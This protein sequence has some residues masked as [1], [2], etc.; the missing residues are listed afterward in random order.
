MQVPNINP[1]IRYAAIHYNHF[2]KPYD[3]LCYDCR[4]FFIKDAKGTFTVNSERLP[5]SDCTVFYLP[6]GSKYHM[7]LRKE[8]RTPQ[9]AVIDF[10]LVQDFNYLHASLSTA[11]EQTFDAKRVIVYPMPKEFSNPLHKKLPSVQ[12]VLFKCCEEFQTQTLY[13]KELASTLLK[14]ALIE[15]IRQ[16]NSDKELQKIEPI[17]AYIKEQYHNV[18]LSNEMLAE[19]FNYHPYYLSQLFKQCT[20]K[21]LHRYLIQYRI[22]IARKNLITTN[23][24]IQVIAWKSGFRSVSYFV[25]MFREHTGKTPGTYRKEHMPFLF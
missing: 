17:L 14:L 16:N 19:R 25:K 23:D 11:N 1:H 2:D 15:L 21:T 10:D 22:N 24:S 18:E 20:G 3:S 13:Y 8:S 4:L 5:F 7:Y 12:D 6:P 9:I